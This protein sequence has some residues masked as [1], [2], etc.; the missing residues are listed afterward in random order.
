MATKDS[1]AGVGGGRRARVVRDAAGRYTPS[2]CRCSARCDGR[3][4]GE[5]STR[6]SACGN[7]FSAA[8]TGA[9]RRFVVAHASLPSRR[10]SSSGAREV[11]RLR[12]GPGAARVEALQGPARVPRATGR[13]EGRYVKTG[14]GAAETVGTGAERRGGKQCVRSECEPNF[15]V[16]RGLAHNEECYG[17]YTPMAFPRAAPRGAARHR[18][19]PSTGRA[20]RSGGFDARCVRALY[21]CEAY[22]RGESR[23]RPITP[24]VWAQRRSAAGLG[25][26]GDSNGSCG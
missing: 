1:L 15:T 24:C 18:A 6:G 14:T 26:V 11:G 25:G 5:A 22:W 3:V 21:A 4:S 8:A 13:P 20:R 16:I 9:A 17:R 19:A 23:W 7:T 2:S 10:W 12:A